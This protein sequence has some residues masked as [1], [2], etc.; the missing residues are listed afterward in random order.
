M[1]AAPHSVSGREVRD[2]VPVEV[3]FDLSIKGQMNGEGVEKCLRK[4]KYQVKI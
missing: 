3:T 4:K 2:S 1:G